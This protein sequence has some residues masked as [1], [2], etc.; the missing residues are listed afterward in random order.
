MNVRGLVVLC[1]L[2]V[3]LNA[4]AQPPPAQPQPQ[5]INA[6][7]EAKPGETTLS[8]A[9][10][11]AIC[12]PVNESTLT[13]L[14]GR[15][16]PTVAAD[17]HAARAKVCETFPQLGATPAYDLVARVYRAS[18]PPL[19]RPPAPT[20]PPEPTDVEEQGLTATM[21]A[22]GVGNF[23]TERAEQEVSA[24]ATVELF[25][26]LCASDVKSVMPR[27]CSLLAGQDNGANPVGL[28]LLKRTVVKDLEALPEHLLER[29]LER[30]REAR[31]ALESSDP[32][33]AATRKKLERTAEDLCQVDAGVALARAL[34]DGKKLDE[35][36]T[37]PAATG[38][39]R[40]RQYAVLS[41]APEAAPIWAA[42]EKAVNEGGAETTLALQSLYQAV[43]ALHTAKKQAEL[44]ARRIT[45]AESSVAWL[46]LVDPAQD[47]AI[48]AEH[49]KLLDELASLTVAVWNRDWV[50]VVA[51]SASADTLG[52]LLL[53]ESDL[54]EEG[55]K[56]D[57]KIRL[58][59]S[60]AADIA[61]AESSADVQGALNR[62]V[63][64]IGSWRRKFQDSFTFN[65][66][67]Y[68][69][70]KY[71]YENIEGVAPSGTALA[72]VLA[73]G[74]ELTFSLGF[75]RLGV[76]GQVVDVGNVASVYFAGEDDSGLTEVEATPDITWAQL[77]S[78][79]GYLVFAPFKAPFVIG[80]GGDYVPVLRQT[81]G[82]PRSVWHLGG[83]LAV[84]VPILEL[85]HE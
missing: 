15:A 68:V 39:R 4:W 83:F 20:T 73:V 50:E 8:S 72:P 28:G 74:L 11:E 32:K 53:C 52:P 58:L 26:R 43:E 33:D 47:A 75:G 55:C 66:Q 69:G 5:C 54:G 27:T 23:L 21:V 80:A 82:G 31:D 59:L 25:S 16:C 2:F 85:A 61:A 29:A 1:A 40:L 22:Q 3:S 49:E 62:V 38:L 18:N 12:N 78:P 51:T 84:D 42:L 35:L 81:T 37:K 17:F 13:A 56:R 44:R 34:R 45:V 57:E 7:L 36:F 9:E 46:A 70:G 64:P 79:G 65:L 41:S 24:F 30:V 77:F 6:F 48:K 67:G 14:V 63:E 76:F 60:V 19:P 10:V 71:A